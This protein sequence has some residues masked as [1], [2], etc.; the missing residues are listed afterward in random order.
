MTTTPFLKMYSHGHA[1]REPNAAGCVI[2]SRLNP[3]TSVVRARAPSLKY[4]LAGEETYELNGRRRTLRAGE[5]MLVEAG[6]EAIVRT[7]RDQVTLGLCVYLGAD[8]T[9]QPFDDLLAEAIVFGDE[10]S[11]LGGLLRQQ[12]EALHRDGTAG[13]AMAGKLV[14]LVSAAA[15]DFLAGIDRD[16]ERVASLRRSTRIETLRRVERAKS[17]IHSH[18]DGPLRLD[19]VAR[20][21]ALSRFHLTRSFSEVV[22]VPP[23]AY[24]RRLRLQGA[25]ERLRDGSRTAT[26]IAEDLGY[27][28]LSAFN[29]AFRQRFG[30]PPSQAKLL[31]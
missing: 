30:V 9:A 6:Q 11:P 15:D 29:R 12:A 4:V 5:F 20:H 26:E 3:G 28:T 31:A 10:E 13:S 2:L 19:E 17:F 25:A 21:A 23:L 16:A 8:R 22:G 7:S 1:S 18:G 27:S 14:A 24:H